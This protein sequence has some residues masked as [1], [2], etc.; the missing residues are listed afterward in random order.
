MKM[1]VECIAATLCV[2]SVATAMPTPGP[3]PSP[4]PEATMVPTVQPTGT[5]CVSIYGDGDRKSQG[6]WLQDHYA[7][8]CA[9]FEGYAQTLALTAA[10]ANCT[11]KGTGWKSV[12]NLGVKSWCSYEDKDLNQEFGCEE[13]RIHGWAYAAVRCCKYQTPA[14]TPA[15]GTPADEADIP[16]V[17]AADAALCTEVDQA[18][19]DDA[20]NTFQVLDPELNALP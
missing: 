15:P 4:T 12:K 18:A 11:A 5:P 14:A 7:R 8:K 6:W 3:T 16:D 10:K 20:D 13:A 19:A 2:V 9:E 1:A 17:T